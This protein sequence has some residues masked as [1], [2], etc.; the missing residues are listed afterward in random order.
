MAG[1]DG[2]WIASETYCVLSIVINCDK[3]AKGM[4][5]FIDRQEEINALNSLLGSVDFLIN[6][7]CESNESVPKYRDDNTKNK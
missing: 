2:G 7:L 6:I 5:D 4:A 3:E 1:G